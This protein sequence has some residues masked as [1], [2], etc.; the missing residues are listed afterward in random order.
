MRWPGPRFTVRRLMVAIAILALV[1]GAIS[2][3]AEMRARSATYRR[4]AWGFEMMTLRRNS[5]VPTPDGRWVSRYDHENHL[6]RDAWAWR[7][8]AKYLRL[9]YYP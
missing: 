4:R 9:S 7:M 1:F 2:W 5:V 6:L 3:V 8:A